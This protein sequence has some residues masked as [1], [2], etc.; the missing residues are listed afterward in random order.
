MVALEGLGDPSVEKAAARQGEPLIQRLPGE[1]VPELEHDGA[2]VSLLVH[3]ARLNELLH[4]HPHLGAG[5]L[6]H[7]LEHREPRGTSHDGKGLGHR[8][9]LG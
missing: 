7:V 1:G 6:H 5:E 4:G 2:T 3:Q 9:G 8:D